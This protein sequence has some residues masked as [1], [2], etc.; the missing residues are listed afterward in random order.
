[1]A[2]ARSSQERYLGARATSRLR[3]VLDANCDADVLIA[4]AW[5]SSRSARKGLALDIYGVM[6]T[7]QMT[8]AYAVADKLSKLLRDRSYR[9]GDRQVLR[10]TEAI[11]LSLTVLKWWKKPTCRTCDGHGHP[12]LMNSPVVDES[13]ECPDCRGTGLIPLERLFQ[14]QH[15]EHARWLVGEIESMCS[16]VFND[17]ARVLSSRMDF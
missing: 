7:E 11:D 15:V 5:A 4:A 2:E 12:L 14:P 17:M 1:M 13:R 6:V 10:R 3:L 9:N 8:G 16:M